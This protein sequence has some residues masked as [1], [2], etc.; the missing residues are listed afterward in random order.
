MTEKVWFFDT[1]AGC[2]VK[3]EK[4]SEKAFAISV[5]QKSGKQE[6]YA[7]GADEVIDFARR[8]LTLFKFDSFTGE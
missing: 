3:L 6:V 1:R 5:T 8:I 2:R 4:V 7:L